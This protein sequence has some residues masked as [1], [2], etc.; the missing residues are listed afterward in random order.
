MDRIILNQMN[1]CWS[2][3]MRTVRMVL[4]VQ[5]ITRDLEF[6]YSPHQ[7]PAGFLT[8][9]S[10]IQNTFP[11]SQW[12][13]GLSTLVCIGAVFWNLISKK[14]ASLLTVTSSYRSYTCFPFTCFNQD[15]E[16]YSLIKQH[17]TLLFLT[18]YNISLYWSQ[19]FCLHGPAHLRRSCPSVL[20]TFLCWRTYNIPC[21]FGI[22]SQRLS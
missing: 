4:S 19:L 21:I 18:N 9:R 6:V 20:C 12:M 10:S 14:T 5:S 16:I 15:M 8:Y 1:D 17:R 22:N 11:V 13:C 2:H 7:R 3:V